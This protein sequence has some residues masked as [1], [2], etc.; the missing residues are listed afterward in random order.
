MAERDSHHRTPWPARLSWPM[1]SCAWPMRSGKP[2]V[3]R[4]AMRAKRGECCRL[5]GRSFRLIE[6]QVLF[7]SQPHIHKTS[8]T[9]TLTPLSNTAEF[10]FPFGL[11][12]LARHELNA[13]RTSEQRLRRL[14][15]DSGT[16]RAKRGA[17]EHHVRRYAAL[18][19]SIA[20]IPCRDDCAC[21][22]SNP[23][24]STIED[25]VANI[26]PGALA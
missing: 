11:F 23:A 17:A 16:G 15:E 25:S 14:G 10:L 5:C 7:R 18:L 13:S 20:P 3:L 9:L 8:F 6:I 4:P 19:A 26:F 1:R 2:A 24:L 12:M 22:C 21:T